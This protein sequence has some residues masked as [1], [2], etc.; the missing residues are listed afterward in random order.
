MSIPAL[1][2]LIKFGAKANSAFVHT[3]CGLDGRSESHSSPAGDVGRGGI[4]NGEGW[5]SLVFPVP[6]FTLFQERVEDP[7]IEDET[8]DTTARSESDIGTAALATG[9]WSDRTL[10]SE[11]SN[12]S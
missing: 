11:E 10:L 7:Q 4:G 9:N 8:F 5:L 12:D 3:L 2:N 6:Q 1:S